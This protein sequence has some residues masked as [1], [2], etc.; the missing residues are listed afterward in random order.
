MQNVKKC[1]LVLKITFAL[2]FELG[3]K[4]PLAF[5]GGKNA[6]VKKVVLVLNLTF[7]LT[8]ALGLMQTL[9]RELLFVN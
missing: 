7:V 4:L 9:R 2:T 3:V 1:K 8:F 5:A 6:N